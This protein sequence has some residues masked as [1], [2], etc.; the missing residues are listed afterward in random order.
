MSQPLAPWDGPEAGPHAHPGSATSFPQNI[1]S[2]CVPGTENTITTSFPK[3]SGDRSTAPATDPG[4][5]AWPEH[6]VTAARGREGP[7]PP[8]LPG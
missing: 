5:A 2:L 3:Q 1:W 4:R 6:G 7:G 8:P